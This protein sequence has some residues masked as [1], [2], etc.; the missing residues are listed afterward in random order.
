MK[1]Y[2]LMTEYRTRHIPCARACLTA[3]FLTAVWSP[4]LGQDEGGAR[5]PAF[6]SFQLI[7][8]RNI[9]DPNRRE[10]RPEREAPPPTPRPTRTREILLIGTIIYERGAFAFFEGTER[11]YNT[12]MHVGEEIAGYQI[13]T[14]DTSKIVLQKEGQQVDLQIGLGLSK[15]DEEEWKIASVQY[16][17][18]GDSKG[19]RAVESTGKTSA[20]DSDSGKEESQTDSDVMKRL[21]ERRR[22]EM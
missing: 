22:R 5:A 14:I 13:V 21:M 17:R 2:R 6:E 10:K 3:V 8:D 7:F 11:E 1:A 18:G 20:K 4:A 15:Q 16:V 9:F 19:D 12:A